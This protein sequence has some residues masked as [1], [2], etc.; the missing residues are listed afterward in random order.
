[1]A[2]ASPTIA[3]VVV[4]ALLLSASTTKAQNFTDDDAAVERHARSVSAVVARQLD[5]GPAPEEKQRF[6]LLRTL[7]DKRRD[8]AGRTPVFL[9]RRAAIIEAIDKSLDLAG[10]QGTDAQMQALA[11]EAKAVFDPVLDLQIGYN[12]ADTYKRSKIGAI[13]PRTFVIVGNDRND[14]R[15]VAVCV[16]A[17]NAAC[18]DNAPIQVIA[19][20][21]WWNT[22][23]KPD[24][25]EVT[26]NP[27]RTYGHPTQQLN[28]TVGL[29]QA[30]PW[31][32]SVTLTDK[33][34]QQKIYYRDGYYW[35]DGQFTTQLTGTL[36]LPVPYAKGSGPNNPNRIAVATQAAAR[37]RAS[38]ELKEATNRILSNV[39]AAYFATV[40]GMEGLEAAIER[41]DAAVRLRDR[42][43]R[44]TEAGRGTRYQQALFD[45]EAAKAAAQVD[46]ALQAFVNQSISLASM[47]GEASGVNGT[48]LYV[49]YDYEKELKAAIPIDEKKAAATARAYSP[50]LHVADLNTA[51]ARMGLALANNQ[52]RPDI[53]FSASVT[54]GES[55]ATFGHAD[56]FAS[57]M[58]LLG[59]SKSLRPDTISQNYSL[60]YTY[61][62]HNRAAKAREERASLGLEDAQ[63]A[64]R[65]VTTTVARGVTEG[66]AAVQAARA[67]A[68]YA[69]REEQGFRSAYDSQVRRLEAG[70]IGEDE[71]VETARQL[72]A[73]RVSRVAAEA[74]HKMR[75]NDLLS[76]MGTLANAM[77]GELAKSALE[78][79]RLDLLNEG[80]YL[81]YFGRADGVGR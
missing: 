56:P 65:D 31:G 35:N 46:D 3:A 7:L 61:P 9:S 62:L 47:I 50:A 38:W 75:E 10:A 60:T 52:A 54:L 64:E 39:D 37:E 71:V 49:P 15:R 24:W 27:G 33:T 25:E 11:R 22:D 32:G 73:A 59:L 43:R 74:N 48:T 44:M 57:H 55:A 76:T 51:I 53:Q 42:M 63:L 13:I 29:T 72:A 1:M 12:R 26:A 6:K 16:E 18:A 67:R 2:A 17:A 66:L 30:L 58:A 21:F 41:R 23:S 5:P 4:A 34:V 81:S 40:I 20:Q 68:A 28:Y 69:N 70:L 79:R 8:L 80:G 45:S 77:P 36:N 78:R 19:L 14:L